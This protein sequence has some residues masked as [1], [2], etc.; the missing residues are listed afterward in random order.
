M[1]QASWNAQKG[2]RDAQIFTYA[3]GTAGLV[4]CIRFEKVD[5]SH[6]YAARVV[7]GVATKCQYWHLGYY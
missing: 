5:N 7:V 3:C 2:A 6:G 4:D 1:L